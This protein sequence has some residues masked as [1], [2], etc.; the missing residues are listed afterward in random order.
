VPS[1][2]D[3]VL[4]FPSVDDRPEFNCNKPDKNGHA[5]LKNF[6]L[7]PEKK[8][9]FQLKEGDGILNTF[10]SAGEYL[11]LVVD[12]EGELRGE[13]IILVYN[14]GDK[15]S[16]QEKSF[17]AM[18]HPIASIEYFG[19]P[20]KQISFGKGSDGNHD[21]RLY[22]LD[23]NGDRYVAWWSARA[24]REAVCRT[25]LRAGVTTEPSLDQATPTYQ[26]LEKHE[27][28]VIKKF[29]KNPC[30]DFDFWPKSG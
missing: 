2:D 12:R 3:K 17:W 29:E 13:H 20:A 25:L 24:L 4:T 8:K 6:Y 18:K 21:G 15:S 14:F 5:D 27:T 30:D 7:C 26:L 1:A 16:N 23:E 10:T 22:V 9:I 19:P 28:G 11:A